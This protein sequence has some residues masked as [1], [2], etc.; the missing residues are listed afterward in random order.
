[1]WP[2]LILAAIFNYIF[3]VAFTW[4]FYLVLPGVG[5]L[6][7][8]TGIMFGVFLAIIFFP[9]ERRTLKSR[10]F[11]I[12]IIAA[13][14]GVFLTIVGARD[15]GRFEFNFGA[16]LII[17]CTAAWS[18]M[19]VIVRKHLRRLAPMFAVAAIFSIV[20]PLFLTTY[21]IMEGFVIPRAPAGTWMLM[22]LS[23]FVGIGLGHTLYYTSVKEVGIATSSGLNLLIPFMAGVLSYFVFG[24]VL[25]WIQFLG[26]AVLLLGCF[27]VIRVRFRHMDTSK[28][29]TKTAQK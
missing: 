22:I 8:Q 11:V 20:I 29:H 24:E 16:V 9:D 25:T 2:Y 6:I 19:A 23:G 12:G 18:S 14:A 21:F 5:S 4:G 1:M 7:E 13:G 28:T 27:F 26:G 10:L 15:Y 3:Q 17:V